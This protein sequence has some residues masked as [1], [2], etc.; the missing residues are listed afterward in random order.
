M[1]NPEKITTEHVEQRTIKEIIITPEH[2]QRS[3]E[4][5]R[6]VAK[7]KKDGN[8]RCPITDRTTN[9]QVHHIAEFSL[10]NVIDFD[11]LKAFLLVID[12]FGYSEQ[13]ADQPLT[14]IDDIR[15]LLPLATEYHN[16]IN[17]LLGN[18]TGIHNMTF[19]AW[20][21]QFVCKDGQCPVPQE[22]ETIETVLERVD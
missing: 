4:F 3:A 13:M 19:P 16:N 12:P 18:G 7:L 14:H 8:Y 15:N 11:K 1:G 5:R 20:V 6:S 9:I 22:G 10:A 2:G 21:A 17:N